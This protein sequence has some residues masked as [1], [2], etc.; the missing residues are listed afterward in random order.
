MSRERSK[1]YKS[2][3]QKVDKTKIYPLEEGMKIIKELPARKFDESVDITVK[4]NL[5]KNQR[6]RGVIILPHTFGKTKRV[7][8]IA[9]GEKAEEAKKAGADFIGDADIIDKIQK[10]WFDF[11]AVIAT[12]DMMKEV[13]K[14]GPTLGKKGL[15]PNPKTG[16]VTFEIKKAVDEAK[17]G[18][19]EYKSDKDGIIG[20]SVGRASM[21]AEKI[22]ENAKEFFHS[23]SKIRPQDIKGEYIKSFTLSRTMSPGVKIDFKEIL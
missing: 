19:T 1:K 2:D 14:L 18:R 10:G 3:L 8:V 7:V 9:K 11:D 22:L 20:I 5:N 21:E 13:S 6:I 15:M 16:T 17:R 23:L 12:P 4:L